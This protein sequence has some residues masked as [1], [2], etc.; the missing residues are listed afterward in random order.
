[1]D[2]S[3]L[4]PTNDLDAM[5]SSALDAAAGWG[6]DHMVVFS[7]GATDQTVMA[8]EWKWDTSKDTAEFK[9]SLLAYLDIRFR[10]KKIEKSDADCWEVNQETTCVFTQE[11][12]TVCILSPD[13]QILAAIHAAYS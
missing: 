12:R 3:T 5:R 4:L 2:A 10:G 6:G 13:M 1:M 11:K 9:E 8:V 7:N